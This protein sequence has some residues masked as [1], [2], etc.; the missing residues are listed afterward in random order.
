MLAA[1]SL[2]MELKYIVDFLDDYLEINKYPDSSINGL[3]VEGCEEVDKIAFAVDASIQTFTYALEADAEMI[4]CHHGILWNGLSRV[5]GLLKE[6]LKFLLENELSLYAAHIPLDAH[7]EIGNNAM[8]LRFID[9]EPEEKFGEYRGVKIGFAGYTNA[10]FEEILERFESE[11]GDIGYMKFGRDEV[12][13]VASI[14]GRGAGYIEEAKREC[15]DLLITGEIEHSAY[16]LAKDAEI[17]VIYLGH[18]NSETFGIKALMNVVSD[19]L[20]MESEFI[21]IPTDL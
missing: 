8:I 6:R 1:F 10:E 15:V 4:I 14:S 17:N 16:H 2:F 19:K 9:V 11:F 18:Y 7:P 12:E 3:Q 20:G 21:D 5:V 13:K